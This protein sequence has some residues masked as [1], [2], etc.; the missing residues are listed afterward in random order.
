[1]D[2]LKSY[3]NFLILQ[4]FVNHAI[5][6]KD[7]PEQCILGTNVK[8]QVQFYNCYSPNIKYKIQYQ[9]WINVN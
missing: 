6:I 5:V 3:S 8:Q 2:S 1:M 9:F 7:F 4:N